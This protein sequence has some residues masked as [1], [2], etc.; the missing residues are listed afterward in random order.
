MFV[1]EVADLNSQAIEAIL[2]DV[3]FYIV[4]DWNA[5]GQYWTMAIRNSAYAVLIDG[6]A[7]SSN[8]PLMYQFRYEDT[9]AGS[10]I[11][12]STSGKFTN[13][14]IPRDGF[15]TGKFEL[16]YLEEQDLIDVGVLELFGKT[17]SYAI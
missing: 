3:L 4:L 2:D 12:A 1:L 5:S 15:A 9:P 6:I 8:Y 7:V 17:Y 13:G 16:I 10:L 11:A 14:Y